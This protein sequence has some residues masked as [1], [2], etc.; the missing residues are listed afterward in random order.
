MQIA[1][2]EN[3]S[4]YI[5]TNE[6]FPQCKTLANIRKLAKSNGWLPTSRD[7]YALKFKDSFQIQH[8]LYYSY[9]FSHEFLKCLFGENWRRKLNC[10]CEYDNPLRFLKTQFQTEV[11]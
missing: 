2:Y 1:E 5:N 4:H 6:D 8:K 3:Y 9:L 11:L 10:M 7:S